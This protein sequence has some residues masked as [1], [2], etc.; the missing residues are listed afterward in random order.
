M[1]LIVALNSRALA[2]ATI[3]RTPVPSLDTGGGGAN[4]SSFIHSISI[5]PLQVHYYSEELP[6]QHGICVGVARRSATGNF[7]LRTCPRSLRDG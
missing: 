4:D 3:P 7:E 1:D 2:H 6:T 5:P